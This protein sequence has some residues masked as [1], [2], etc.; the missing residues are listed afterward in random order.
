[1]IAQSELEVELF[2]S[3]DCLSFIELSNIIEII[4]FG[5]L[6][7]PERLNMSEQ[8]EFLYFQLDLD[9]YL[10]KGIKWFILTC[11]GMQFPK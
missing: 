9:L 8:V 5:D 7:I 10:L 6:R 4:K 3:I 11:Q 2:D 1:L